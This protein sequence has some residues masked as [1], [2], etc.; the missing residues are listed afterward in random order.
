MYDVNPLI[1]KYEPFKAFLLTHKLFEQ[2]RVDNGGFG[3]SWNKDLDISCNE[4][5]FK[6]HTHT[7]EK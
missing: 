1:E 7:R 3:I 6:G 5:Y 4:L 2:V